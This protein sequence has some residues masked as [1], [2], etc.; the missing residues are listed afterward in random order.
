MKTTLKKWT[1]LTLALLLAL[2]LTAC[3]TQEQVTESDPGGV[4]TATPENSDNVDNATTEN[5]GDTAE[6][7]S[8]ANFD[9]ELV[10]G[11]KSNAAFHYPT[12]LLKEDGYGNLVEISGDDF[13]FSSIYVYPEGSS[14][15][16]GSNQNLSNNL[17]EEKNFQDDLE[18]TVGSFPCHHASYVDIWD[19]MT[20]CYLLDTTSLGSQ[21]VAAVY[22]KVQIASNDQLP[23]V[24]AVLSTLHLK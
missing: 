13:F 7:A 21:D 19:D 18:Y 16:E 17:K 15:I 12:D 8:T 24:E 4:E 22:V 9:G 2:A 1:A 6:T 23:T 20:H 5:G 11:D 3:G 14:S 10:V